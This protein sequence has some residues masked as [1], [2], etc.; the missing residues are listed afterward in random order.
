MIERRGPGAPP[1]LTVHWL[2]MELRV[3]FRKE[4]KLTYNPNHHYYHYVRYN[5]RT[6]VDEFIVIRTSKRCYRVMYFNADFKYFQYFSAK[7]YRDCA[8]RMIQLYSIFKRIEAKTSPKARK[9]R[10]NG[11]GAK[12]PNTS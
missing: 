12:Y 1:G 6:L 11:V 8:A 5:K 3:P 9:I 10:K 4:Y 7:N 2:E